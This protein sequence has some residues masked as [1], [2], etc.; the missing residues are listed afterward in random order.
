MLKPPSV[1]MEDRGVYSVVVHNPRGTAEASATLG[2]ERR[3]LTTRLPWR[4][5]SRSYTFECREPGP[6]V[7]DIAANEGIL[8][9]TAPGFMWVPFVMA[10]RG[11]SWAMKMPAISF[12][13][14]V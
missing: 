13:R 11:L 4:P 2:G 12:G 1:G 9:A 8:G 5:Q 3:D 10:F 6:V 7:Q 14:D